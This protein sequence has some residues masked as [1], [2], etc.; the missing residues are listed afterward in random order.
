MSNVQTFRK[1]PVEI[2]AVRFDGTSFSAEGIKAWVNGNGGQATVN[3]FNW[4]DYGRMELCIQ[5]LEGRM[6][7]SD[8]D[9]VI[10]GVAG[11]FYPCKP[12]IFAATY[13]AV[14]E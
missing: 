11:E 14:T 2:E 9:Y 3:Y 1:K 6:L 4:D 10:R 8:G 13:D 7:V 5:T 12:D